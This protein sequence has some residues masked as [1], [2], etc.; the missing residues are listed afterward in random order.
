M[1]AEHPSNRCFGVDRKLHRRLDD[2]DHSADEERFVLIGLSR[3][4]RRLVVCHC[5]RL[6]GDTICII[7]ARKATPREAR[8]Y[9]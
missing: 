8:F 2:P 7:S 4:L 1:A 3:Q 5:Y 9:P 6:Q